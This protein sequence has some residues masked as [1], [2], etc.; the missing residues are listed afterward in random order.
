MAPRGRAGTKLLRESTGLVRPKGWFQDDDA[1]RCRGRGGGV[2]EGA[3]AG[4]GARPGRLIDASLAGSPGA[5]Q[6]MDVQ[7]F[8]TTLRDGTQSEGLSLSVED[9]LKIARLLDG[10]GIHFIEGGYPGSNPKDVEFFQRAQVADAQAR[11]ADRVRHDPQGGRRGGGR[12]DPARAGRRARRRRSA[13]SASR[14]PAR[15]QGA[16]H[17]AGREPGDDRATASRFLKTRGREVVYDAEHFF[18]G[19]R[20]DRDYALATLKA[21]ADGG[22]RLDHACATPTAAA[23]PSDDR[24]GGAAR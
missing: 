7:L 10:F 2:G 14:G 17:D 3:G 18:D 20:A 1:A 23:C 21:A 19:Y 16:R 12:S 22:R 8:D 15:H 5:P 6:P 24:R 4:A 13:S 11:Q 9:K